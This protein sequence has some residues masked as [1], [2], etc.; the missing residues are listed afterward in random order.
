MPMLQETQPPE[1]LMNKNFFLLWQ[2]QLVSQLGASVFQIA[3]LFWVKHATG[4]ATVMGLMA[5]LGA[6][7]GIILGPIGGTF[8][9]RHSRRTIIIASDLLR[10][11][12]SLALAAFLFVVPDRTGL[13]LAVLLS[14]SVISGTVGSFFGPAV[15]AAIPDIVPRNRIAAA[16]SF[17]QFSSQ[18]AL[19]VGQGIGG[20]LFRL[21]GTPILAVI[22]ALTFIFSAGSESFMY[23]PQSIPESKGRLK[24]TLRDF[25]R[26]L[27]EGM[28]YVWEKR[29][30]KQLVIGAAAMNFFAIPITLLL[31]FYVEDFLL[32][33][34]DWLGYLYA[35][36]GLGAIAGYALA[37]TL[38]ISGHQRSVMLCT[39]FLAE[40]I[41]IVAMGS[42]L[43]PYVVLAVVL[44]IGV[45]NGFTNII[46]STIL[47]VTTP[48]EIRG[49][50]FGI[51]STITASITP[52]AMGLTGLIADLTGQNIPVIYIVSGITM[53]LICLALV[54]NRDFR[55]FVGTEIR[56]FGSHSSESPPARP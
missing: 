8:A 9:D 18:L 28:G 3:I 53:F 50:V 15:S 17:S 10:A 27:K 44:A 7:P 45:A 29:G 30:L 40:A 21:L 12:N 13:I 46:I 1:K 36:F 20:V 55:A 47:Q 24:D 23:I 56:V 5:M 52:L 39:C 14:M 25:L 41:L 35:T 22:D 43:A 2:G 32:L 42:L 54:V 34:P 6:I 31:P 51:V 49:R 4:S 38:Q 26:D 11:L 33:K 48:S 19:I 16:N 37:G